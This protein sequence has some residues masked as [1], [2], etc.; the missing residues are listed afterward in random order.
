MLSGHRGIRR[1]NVT[2]NRDTN[3]KKKS[4]CYPVFLSFFSHVTLE[5]LWASIAN[6][7]F[8]SDK[9]IHK[10]R[11]WKTLYSSRE[12]TWE[13]VYPISVLHDKIWWKTTTKYVKWLIC[14]IILLI[15]HMF[16]I[17]TCSTF[18]HTDD[19][20]AAISDW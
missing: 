8:F 1:L 2:Q 13:N 14:S 6:L 17:E 16:S 12:V 10:W 11:C 3:L 9:N 7:I 15:K 20:S 4:L 18:R 19:F 5:C